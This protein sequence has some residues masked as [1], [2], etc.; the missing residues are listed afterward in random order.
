LIVKHKKNNNKNILHF[1]HGNSITPSS[2]SSILDHLNVNYQVNNYL[3]RPLWDNKKIP[4]FKN[5]DIFLNDYLIDIENCNNISAVGHSIGGNILLRAALEKPK[6]FNKIILLDPTLLSPYKVLIWKAICAF[7]LQS[8][9]LPL[10]NK[11]RKKRMNYESYQEIFD[12]YRSKKI[13][14]DFSDNQ[15]IAFIKSITICENGKIKLI[16]PSEWD[17]KIY[18][19]G[20]RDDYKIWRKIKNL[21]VEVVI[22]R[23]TKSNIFFKEAEKSLKKKSSKIKFSIIEGDHFFP[24]N[25]P[26]ETINLLN[27][28]L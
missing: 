2:Y 3:L 20:M 18:S 21:N 14:I 9:F 24:I 12:S 19:Q 8:Q 10:I 22:V 23:A 27:K 16:F 4:N 26:S 25:K 17:A 7:N 1:L 28:Y 13:F 6:K 5:W 15:L 11:A